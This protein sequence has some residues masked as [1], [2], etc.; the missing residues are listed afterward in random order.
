MWALGTKF[1]FKYILTMKFPRAVYVS[2][3]ILI[4]GLLS[5]MDYDS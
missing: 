2:L 3:E 1:G 5:V 4:E